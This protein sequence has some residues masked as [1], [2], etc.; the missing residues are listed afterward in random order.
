MQNHLKAANHFA[1]LASYKSIS[2]VERQILMNES[3]YGY[4]PRRNVSND[5]RSDF[6]ETSQDVQ[7]EDGKK[8][9]GCIFS[10]F[11]HKR[12]KQPKVDNNVDVQSHILNTI[13]DDLSILSSRHIK[14]EKYRID[15]PEQQDKVALNFYN[16]VNNKQCDVLLYINK[17]DLI[18]A[19][20][21][22]C[23]KYGK[24]ALAKEIITVLEDSN[25]RIIT[26]L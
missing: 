9:K 6:R 11:F 2:D 4:E 13:Y 17:G 5:S 18:F 3:G 24:E 16:L 20:Q 1:N 15:D 8:K 7:H 19:L 25:G 10:P 14:C 21:E 23:V 22:K 26:S 12:D